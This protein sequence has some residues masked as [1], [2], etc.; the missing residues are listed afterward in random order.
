[1]KEINIVKIPGPA[2]KD[3]GAVR[4]GYT[5]PAFPPVRTEPASVADK[6][7]VHMGQMTPAFPP[8]R[9]Q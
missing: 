7:K 9:A 3:N 6:A 8:A 4:M 1:M 5:T 2:I